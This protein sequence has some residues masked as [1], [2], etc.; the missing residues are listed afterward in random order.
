MN[1]YTIARHKNKINHQPKLNVFIPLHKFCNFFKAKFRLLIYFY[2]VYLVHYKYDTNSLYNS[3]IICMHL[4]TIRGTYIY[5]KIKFAIIKEL[6]CL[7]ICSETSCAT[8]KIGDKRKLI[9]K[10]PLYCQCHH[11][12]RYII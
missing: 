4:V 8:N 6:C 2:T 3:N 9:E 5:F 1:G 10:I 7:R 12:S 11:I